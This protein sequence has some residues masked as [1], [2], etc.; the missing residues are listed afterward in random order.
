MTNATQIIGDYLSPFTIFCN[1]STSILNQQITW[2]QTINKTGIYLVQNSTSVT[3]SS[4]GQQLNFAKLAL[5]NEEY[6]SCGYLVS[7]TTFQ[8]ANNYFLYI[9]G[10]LFFYNIFFFQCCFGFLESKRTRMVI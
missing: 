8:I 4:G 1:Q 10:T 5:S 9:R 2:I 3:I 6:Y 7:N